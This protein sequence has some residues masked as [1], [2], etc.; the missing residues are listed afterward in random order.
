[1]ATKT[2]KYT[3][4]DYV[5]KVIRSFSGFGLKTES[6]IPKGVCVIE[7]TGRVI[8]KEEEERSRG[9]YLFEVSKTKTID[10]SARSN[11]ARYINHSCKPNCEPIIHSG[12]VLI[13]STRRIEAGEE[14]TYDYGEEYVAEHINPCKCGHCTPSI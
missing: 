4:G 9:R 7:Y 14:L 12:K 2:S 1:M 3:P 13:M 11:T 6:D 8:S 10:G 5:F